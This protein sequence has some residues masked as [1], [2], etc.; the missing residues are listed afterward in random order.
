MLIGSPVKQRGVWIGAP[1]SIWFRALPAQPHLPKSGPQQTSSFKR[2]VKIQIDIHKLN[3]MTVRRWTNASSLCP[4]SSSLLLLCVI[5]EDKD[6]CA[7]GN[8]AFSSI[9]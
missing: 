2:R 7:L 6:L 4:S 1:S 5:L 8:I 9:E 3:S